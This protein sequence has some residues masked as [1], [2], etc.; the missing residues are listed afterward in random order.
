M[1]GMIDER[2]Y[3]TVTK[4]KIFQ[5]QIKEN[6]LQLSPDPDPFSLNKCICTFF[7]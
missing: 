7:C 3:C 1:M 4:F 2:Y 6:R 5:V